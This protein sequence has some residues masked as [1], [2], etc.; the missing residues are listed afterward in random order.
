MTY[1]IYPRERAGQYSIIMD[2]D[3]RKAVLLSDTM[4]ATDGIAFDA[5]YNRRDM[6]AYIVV[7][8]ITDEALLRESVAY[9]MDRLYTIC[10]EVLGANDLTS[11]E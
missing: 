9:Q 4:D 8:H 10:A 11:Y 6:D 5:Y 3:H 2:Y 7:V 1:K